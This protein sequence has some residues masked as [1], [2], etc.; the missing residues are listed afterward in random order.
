MN[1]AEKAFNDLNA[2]Y[3]QK[4]STHERCHLGGRHFCGNV[5]NEGKKIF[6]LGDMKELGADSKAAH[7]KIAE[8]IKSGTYILRLR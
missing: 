8:K 5:N 6:V 2:E 1:N 7:E 4:N 3:R